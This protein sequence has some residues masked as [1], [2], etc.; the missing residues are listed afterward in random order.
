MKLKKKKDK[1]V[2]TSVLLTRGNKIILKGHWREGTGMAG[3]WREEREERNDV[4]DGS[5]L[6]RMIYSCLSVSY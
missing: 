2:D 5:L 3:V 4:H 1:S 6:A